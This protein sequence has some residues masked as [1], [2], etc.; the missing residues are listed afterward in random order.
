MLSIVMLR[1]TRGQHG[2]ANLPHCSAP[3]SFQKYIMT[4]LLFSVQPLSF[5]SASRVCPLS[6]VHFVTLSLCLFSFK[7]LSC[8]PGALSSGIAVPSYLIN[9]LWILFAMQQN[10]LTGEPK[11]LG[12]LEETRITRCM[13]RGNKLFFFFVGLIYNS[14]TLKLSLRCRAKRSWP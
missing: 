14:L 5:H 1:L 10:W 4:T 12:G 11:T 3:V 9:E 7:R 2:K 8:L 6:D 13:C